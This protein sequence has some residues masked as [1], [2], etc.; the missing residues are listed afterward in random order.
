M[1]ESDSGENRKS[2]IRSLIDRMRNCSASQVLSIL[3]PTAQD[4][5]S[6][7]STHFW[8]AGGFGSQAELG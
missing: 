4:P 7:R 6:L 1:N 2:T 8:K 3:A 5:E